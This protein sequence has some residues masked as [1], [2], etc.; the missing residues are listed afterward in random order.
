MSNSRS[1][2]LQTRTSRKDG[3]ELR[4]MLPLNT[5]GKSY[6]GSPSTQPGL[7]FDG[8]LKPKVKLVATG[9]PSSHIIQTLISQKVVKAS[10]TIDN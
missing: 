6:M 3:V 5:N 7:S 2:T 10:V 1:P 4:H 9:H 8:S